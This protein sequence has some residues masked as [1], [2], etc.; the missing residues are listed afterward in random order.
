MTVASSSEEAANIKINDL[1]ITLDSLDL[2]LY[3]CIEKTNQ[4]RQKPL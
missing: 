2:I 4:I 1:Q 3:K